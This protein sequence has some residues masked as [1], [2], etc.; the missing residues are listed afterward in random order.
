MKRKKAS[1]RKKKMRMLHVATKLPENNPAELYP[2]CLASWTAI[3]ADKTHFAT[4]PSIGIDTDL[5]A[6]N[7]ALE[8]AP[9]GGVVETAAIVGAAEKVRQ[10][11]AQ[12]APYVEGVLRALPAESVPPILAAIL[13]YQS[14][15]GAR[16]PKAEIA[17]EAAGRDAVGS[18]AA[19]RPR[20]VRGRH[21]LLGGQH[22]SSEL[23]ARRA[24]RADAL[25]RHRAHARGRCTTSASTCC[26]ARVGC[27]TRRRW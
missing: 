10:D 19:H 17:G 16:P 26:C 24:V 6:L 15:A 11:F 21:L 20:G 25:Q 18:G 12:L 2:H 22:G 3:K 13:M 7:T 1:S 8:D 14:N 4:P 5:A 27:R 23:V 9:G